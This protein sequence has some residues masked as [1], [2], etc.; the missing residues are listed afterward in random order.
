MV[1]TPIAGLGTVRGIKAIAEITGQSPASLPDK[2]PAVVTSPLKS[3]PSVVTANAGSSQ[4][5]TPVVPT[6]P[7]V[8]DADDEAKAQRVLNLG[9]AYLKAGMAD[10]AVGKFRSITTSYAGTDA[11]KEAAELVKQYQ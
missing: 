6:A 7:T 5:T 9:K 10:K 1:D 4:A 2:G 8:A 3:K 11:A